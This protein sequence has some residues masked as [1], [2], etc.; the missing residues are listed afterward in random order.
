M[1]SLRRK[2]AGNFRQCRVG[3]GSEMNMLACHKS[4]KE[5]L[6]SVRNGCLLE[7]DEGFAAEMGRSKIQYAEGWRHS[8]WASEQ[9]D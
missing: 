2:S 5:W 1:D 6:M 9:R 7:C 4:Q 8:W 3:D